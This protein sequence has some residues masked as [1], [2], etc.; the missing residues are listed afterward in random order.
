MSVAV[1]PFM[2]EPNGIVREWHVQPDGTY[3]IA[4]KQN[5]E[6]EVLERNKAM[7]NHNDGYTPSRDMQRVA[8]IPLVFIEEYMQRGINL[9]H[10]ENE[11]ILA[12]ILDDSEFLYFR[13]AHGRIGKKSRHV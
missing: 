2:T 6:T 9:Y 11:D 13:T 7:Y 12:R 4:T 10:P 8:S 3:I 5:N 1:V